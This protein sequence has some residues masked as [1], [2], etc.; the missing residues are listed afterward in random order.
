[1]ELF[2]AN[3]YDIIAAYSKDVSGTDMIKLHEVAHFNPVASIQG[4]GLTIVNNILGVLSRYKLI[5]V[6]YRQALSGLIE[7]KNRTSSS[8]GIAA[9]SISHKAE[10]QLLNSI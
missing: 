1:M 2:A 8:L 4:K 10:I 7:P 5:D 3:P 6:I 9:K